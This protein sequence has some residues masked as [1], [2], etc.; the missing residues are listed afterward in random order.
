ML[1]KMIVNIECTKPLSQYERN[2]ILI[3]DNSTQSYHIT[4][5]EEFLKEHNEKFDN[6]ILEFEKLKEEYN[7]KFEQKEQEQKEFIEESNK[8]MKDFLST[9]KTTNEKMINLIKSVIYKEEN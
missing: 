8:K 3:Y 4:T 9:Y 6:L 5:K 1:Q 7:Q 2:H